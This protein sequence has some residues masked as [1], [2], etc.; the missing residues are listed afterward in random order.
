MT[1]DDE[2]R[3][4]AIVREEITRALGALA[5]EADHLDGWDSDHIESVA[6]GAVKRSAEGAA[7][8]LN[9]DHP[10]HYPWHGASRCGRC[11]E[12]E[13]LPD[14]PFEETHAQG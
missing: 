11:G 13:I 7:Y 1:K 10:E 5:R 4:R 12:P 2:D 6:L 3:V 14:N 9:C 8:R